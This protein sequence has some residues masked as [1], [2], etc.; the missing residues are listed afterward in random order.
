MDHLQNELKKEFQL[1][2][3]ILF[4]DAVF[5]IA[6]TLLAIDLKIPEV[7]KKLIT[8]SKL[9]SYLVE[10]IPRFISFIVSFFIIGNFWITHHRMF[11]FVVNYNRKLLVGNLFLLFGIAVMPFSTAFYSQYVDTMLD[12][13]VFIYCFNIAYV[14]FFNT[15]LWRIISNP[16]NNLSEGL[17]P[18]TRKYI[19]VRSFVLPAAILIILLTFIFVNKVFALQMFNAIP[20]VIYLASFKTKKKIKHLNIHNS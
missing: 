20:L 18:L 15:Y 5:A 8:E 10:L 14:G 7:S 12:S 4:S 11:G 1:E 2:R 16:K 6:I 3:M 9:D 13:P 17:H 19:L